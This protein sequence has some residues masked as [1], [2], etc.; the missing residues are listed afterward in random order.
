[1]EPHFDMGNIVRF[2]YP[3]IN[4]VDSTTNEPLS[5]GW[6]VY[7]VK[8]KAGLADGT[9][10]KNTGH[11]FFD[12]NPAIVTNT[13]LNTIDIEMGITEGGQATA[14]LIYPNPAANQVTIEFGEEVSGTLSLIDLSG[15]AVR[16]RTITRSEKVTLD[17]EGLSSGLYGISMPGVKLS[18]NRVQVIR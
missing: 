13:T 9:Q 18:R 10:I 3:N 16:S 11:I 1:M 15:K 14:S 2:D 8:P 7:K 6:V 5:H 12:Y 4:L 17:L